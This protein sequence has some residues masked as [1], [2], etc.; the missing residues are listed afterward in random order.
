[1]LGVDGVIVGLGDIAVQQ[2]IQSH[3]L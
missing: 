2:S 3:H 1:M